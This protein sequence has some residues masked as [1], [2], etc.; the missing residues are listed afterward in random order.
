MLESGRPRLGEDKRLDLKEDVQ[1]FLKERGA[2]KMRVA[3]PCVGFE[4]AIKG[5]HPL[6]IMKNAESVIVFGV[7]VGSDFYRT[8]NIEGKTEADDRIGHIFRDWLAY[9]LVEFLKGR[10]FNALLPRGHFDKQ[11]NIARMSFKMAAHEAGFGAYGKSGL[12]VTPE[13]GPRVNIGVV[14]T[15]AALEPD[16]KLVFDPCASCS[17][18]A[19][20]CPANAIQR[21]SKPPVSHNRETCVGF[22]Q[23]LRNAT[24]DPRFFCGYC[25]DKCPVGMTTKRGF[26]LSR[27]RRLADLSSRA[28]NSLIRRASA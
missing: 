12:I 1:R 8:V 15:E 16:K 21:D 27:Y 9:E 28:R 19:A 18:C 10:G 25:Y 3:N 7:Y 26:R 6:D 5:C 20:A 17:V 23:R 14:V 22:I 24:N 2:F 11:R 13:Y 4:K